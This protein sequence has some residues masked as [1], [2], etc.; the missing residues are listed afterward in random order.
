MKIALLT[1]THIG[2]KN[3]SDV[4]NRYF[5]DYYKNEFFSYLEEHNI[6]DIIHLGDIFDRRKYV[7]FSTL[8]LWHREFFSELNNYNTHIIIG[9]HDVYYKDSN[10]INSPDLLLEKYDNISIHKSACELVFDDCKIL[11]VP[12]I[13]DRNKEASLARIESTD[14]KIL[15]GHLEIIGFELMSGVTN[16]HG[17]DISVFSKFDNVYTGHF[18]KRSSRNNVHYLGSTC[19]ITWADYGN[20]NGFHIFDTDKRCTEFIENKTSIFQKIFYQE[21]YKEIPKVQGKYVKLVVKNKAA[22]QAYLFEKYIESLNEQNPAELVVIEEDNNLTESNQIVDET[23]D[24]FTI[25]QDYVNMSQIDCDKDTLNKLFLDLYQEA[26]Q[27]DS[28]G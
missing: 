8:D 3:D 2:V 1:D 13:N 22:V 11:F 23:K 18:H 26:E 9:N 16:D 19:K 5:L 25:L 12:W 10:K 24:T 27:Y 15:M 28:D 7:N 6:R 4:F 20:D 14:A 21:D 17:F